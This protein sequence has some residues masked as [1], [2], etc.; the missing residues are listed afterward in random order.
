MEQEEAEIYALHL[1]SKA[2]ETLW[3]L[4]QFEDVTDIQG[5]VSRQDQELLSESKS[6]AI[7]ICHYYLEM[8]HSELFPAVKKKK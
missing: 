8:E 2:A 5:S 4:S 7:Q 3:Y 6:L 1:A